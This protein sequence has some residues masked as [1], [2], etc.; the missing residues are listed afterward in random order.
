MPANMPATMPQNYRGGLSRT[1]LLDR[2]RELRR[3]ETDAERFLWMLLRSR[4]IAGAK[5][6]R[7]HQF[8]PFILDFF[9]VEHQLAIEVDGGQHFSDD[10][11][12]YDASRTAWLQRAGVQ[13]LRFDNRQVLVETE[14]VIETILQELGMDEVPSPQPSPTPSPRPSP[15]GRGS[16]RL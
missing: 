9:C 10:G 7:Q 11:L 5:F 6:R 2:C 12:A 13:V 15:R 14:G 16:R 4:Q 1:E 3:S 8:G